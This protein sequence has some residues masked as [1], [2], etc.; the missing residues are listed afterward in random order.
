LKKYINFHEGKLHLAHYLAYGD[1]FSKKPTYFLINC[2]LKLKTTKE[3]SK[4]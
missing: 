1:E 4:V 2:P 3:K